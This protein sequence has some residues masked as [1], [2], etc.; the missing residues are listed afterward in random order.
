MS[1]KCAGPA[2]PPLYRVT[3]YRRDWP[4]GPEI[5]RK[6]YERGSRAEAL[7]LRRQIAAVLSYEAACGLPGRVR[8]Q[9]V[10]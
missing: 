5:A 9:R 6:T 1:E 10:R 4:G 2:A 3:V 8:M 7:A